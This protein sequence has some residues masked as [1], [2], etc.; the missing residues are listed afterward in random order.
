MGARFYIRLVVTL[1]DLRRE[2][3]FSLA[4]LASLA[5]VD[6]IALLAIVGVAGGAPERVFIGIVI[7][8]VVCL[9]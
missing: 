8:R 6:F 5:G 1:F 3:R 4:L 2:V 9:V 7:T